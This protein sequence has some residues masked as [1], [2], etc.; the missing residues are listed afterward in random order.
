MRG[1]YEYESIIIQRMQL[2]LL[3]MS[4]HNLYLSAVKVVSDC[5]RL[6][7]SEFLMRLIIYYLFVL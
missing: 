5:G 2:I 7:Y 1:L 4:L 6:T 3:N